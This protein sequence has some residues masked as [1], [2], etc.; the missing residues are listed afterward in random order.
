MNHADFFH[1]LRR[2]QCRACKTTDPGTPWTDH[3][4]THCQRCYCA[5]CGRKFLTSSAYNVDRER[6]VKVCRARERCARKAAPGA[7]ARGDA[8]AAKPATY[9]EEERLRSGEKALEI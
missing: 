5:D 8:A 6:G 2:G 9:G 3:T 1:P 7:V 4:R